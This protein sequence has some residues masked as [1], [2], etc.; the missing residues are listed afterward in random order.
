MRR[1]DQTNLCRFW[2]PVPL[3]QVIRHRTQ[4]G[5]QLGSR[6]CAAMHM[7][8]CTCCDTLP[9]LLFQ[10]DCHIPRAQGS[11]SLPYVYIYILNVITR[12]FLKWWTG[13]HAIIP[14]RQAFHHPEEPPI[15]N[16]AALFFVH[17]CSVSTAE[18]VQEFS[19][20]SPLKRTVT[21]P[22]Y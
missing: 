20:Q 11:H 19:I 17:H 21:G 6:Q 8:T 9:V 12:H 13:E 16:W 18:T 4:A 14:S 5:Q 2:L 3:S 10:H 1:N 22:S 7:S 15:T